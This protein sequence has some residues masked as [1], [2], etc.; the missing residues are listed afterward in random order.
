[1]KHTL[2]ALEG[3]SHV[4]RQGIAAEEQLDKEIGSTYTCHVKNYQLW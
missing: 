1:M 3:Q 4:I 2:D